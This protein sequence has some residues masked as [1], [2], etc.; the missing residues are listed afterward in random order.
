MLPGSGLDDIV[1][2]MTA[3]IFYAENK[4]NAFGTMERT[5]VYDRTVQ[6]SA[7]SAMSDKIFSYWTKKELFKWKYM[8]TKAPINKHKTNA[9][10][11]LYLIFFLIFSIFIWFGNNSKFNWE[12]VIF[13]IKINI[14]R[15]FVIFNFVFG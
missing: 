7:I 5:W 11:K 6:C 3:E 12:W 10:D 9:K 4:Q 2:P 8:N 13:L 14:S 1:Y 15:K